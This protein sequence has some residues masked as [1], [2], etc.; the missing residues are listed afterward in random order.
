VKAFVIFR[1]RASYAK[2][3]VEELQKVGL[4]VHIVD[5][6]STYPPAVEWLKQVNA[7][8]HRLDNQH[9]QQL[10][11]WPGLRAL[12]GTK[13]PYVVTDCDVIP[14]APDDWVSEL[15]SYLDNPAWNKVGMSLRLADI[16]ESYQ[17]RQKVIEWETQHWE[18]PLTEATRAKVT[19]FGAAV[20][21]TLAIYQPL[22]LYPSFALGPAIRTG[23]P[24]YA[25]HLS[26]YEDSSNPSEE[27][28][29]YEQH[30]NRDYSHWIAPE[31]YS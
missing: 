7:Q 4:E 1:D 13:K 28:Q 14:T 10:W 15:A 21:T 6:A 29:W 3:C 11:T 16:P 8:V 27:Q 19:L 25:K 30:M 5:H 23:Y 26:W 31:R 18:H 24:Y 20:D 17:H 22:G 9:P 12:V 2:Q